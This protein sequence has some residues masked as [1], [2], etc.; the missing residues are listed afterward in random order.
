MSANAFFISFRIIKDFKC[1]LGS[2]NFHLS[3][4]F[5]FQ[6]FQALIDFSRNFYDFRLLRGAP[7]PEPPK[8]PDFQNLNFPLNFREKLDK[9]LK[10]C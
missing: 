3:D 6:N 10:A 9:I 5:H 1:P 2:L 7:Q 4:L 8:N